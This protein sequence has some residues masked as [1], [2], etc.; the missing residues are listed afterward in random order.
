MMS[1]SICDVM[2][3]AIG[4]KDTAATGNISRAAKVQAA[5]LISIKRFI[6]ANSLEHHVYSEIKGKCLATYKVP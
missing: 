2:A 4:A 5:K 6:E 3:G 1:L